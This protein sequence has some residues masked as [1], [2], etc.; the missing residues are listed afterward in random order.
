MIGSRRNPAGHRAFDHAAQRHPARGTRY[1]SVSLSRN[2]M[3]GDVS[4]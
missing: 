3:H 4:S 2:R 1:S